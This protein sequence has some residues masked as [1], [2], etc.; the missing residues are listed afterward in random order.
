MVCSRDE[1]SDTDGWDQHNVVPACV[2]VC[3]LWAR[4]C[5]G[6]YVEVCRERWCV[7]VNVQD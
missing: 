1:D 3:V 6:V 2:C 7:H 5:G 4:V